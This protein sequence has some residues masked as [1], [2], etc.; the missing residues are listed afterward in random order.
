MTDRRPGRIRCQA[1][2]FTFLEM[3]EGWVPRLPEYYIR[4]LQLTSQCDHFNNLTLVRASH[5]EHMGPAIYE[6][7][8]YR[9]G[10][11]AEQARALQAVV[12]YKAWTRDEVFK[13]L[14]TRNKIIFLLFYGQR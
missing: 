5:M 3:W 6:K 10:T 2:Y 11:D 14:T 12:H 9:H 7:M 8:M 4:A 13:G 1:V